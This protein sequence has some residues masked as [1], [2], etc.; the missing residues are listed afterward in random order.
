M[1]ECRVVH[2]E[3]NGFRI[4]AEEPRPRTT[5]G[6]ASKTSGTAPTASENGFHDDRDEQ[7]GARPQRETAL[8]HVRPQRAKR[9]PKTSE[10]TSATSRTASTTRGTAC[11]AAQRAEGRP[12]RAKLELH[13]TCNP[14]SRWILTG[15]SVDGTRSLE[16]KSEITNIRALPSFQPPWSRHLVRLARLAE[17]NT[18]SSASPQNTMATISMLKME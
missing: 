15:R 3:Q 8:R 1:L 4:R 5:S 16:N 2:D 11:A 6:T 18:M 13:N 7:N 10:T 17:T 9:L 14:Y 12:Q